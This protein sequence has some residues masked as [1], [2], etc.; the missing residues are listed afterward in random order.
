MSKVINM[1]QYYSDIYYNLNL[2]KDSYIL[3]TPIKK[4]DTINN[5]ILAGN[6]GKPTSKRY[7]EFIKRVAKK[8][9]HVFIIAGDVEYEGLSRSYINS[10]MNLSLS[11]LRL[12]NV[13]YLDSSSVYINGCKI[14]GGYVFDKSMKYELSETRVPIVVITSKKPEY[15][16]I[17]NLNF[18]YWIYGGTNNNNNQDKIRTNQ[19]GKNWF[20]PLKDFNHNANIVI[21]N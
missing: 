17:E 11:Y 12:N 1:F 7:W 19:Y 2:H 16:N 14:V 9:Y 21:G 5:L 6:I 8:F 20:K 10:F 3:I 13:Y 15:E 18:A 4:D